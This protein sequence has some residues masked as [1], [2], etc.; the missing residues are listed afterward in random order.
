MSGGAYDV[1]VV[2]AGPAGCVAA[3]YAALGGARVL[4]MDRKRDVGVPVQCG[5]FLPHPSKLREVMPRVEGFDELFAY[6]RDCVLNTSGRQRFYA[7]SGEWKEVAVPADTVD[8]RRF[9]KFLAQQ[10]VR[11]GAELAMATTVT[12]VRDGQ[13]RT[14]GAEGRRTYHAKVVVGA[15][16]PASVVARHAGLNPGWDGMSLSAAVEYE[17]CGV[18]HDQDVAELYFGRDWGPGGYAWVIPLGQDRANVGVGVRRPFFA[19][20]LGPREYLHRFIREHPVASAKLRRGQAT[21]RIVGLVPCGGTL[22]RTVA[23]GVLLCGDAGGF[24]MATSGGGIPFAMASGRLAGDTAAGFLRGE[25]QLGDYE[26]RWREQIGRELRVSV[27]VR[28]MVDSLMRSDALMNAVFR[29]LSAEQI[30]GLQKGT[31]SE[32]TKRVLTGI[33]R[34]SR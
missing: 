10:A 34:P 25:C 9:D 32:A 8:R 30:E 24:V 20:G 2:G 4:V 13:V 15:D 14:V 27:A 19:G 1:V 16:G 22:P 7:P 11:A 6:P 23:E 21:A 5:G 26:H 18:E 28:R 3:R 31:L 12:G 17:L 29:V 33:Y